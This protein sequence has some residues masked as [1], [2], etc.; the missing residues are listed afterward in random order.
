VC[1]RDSTR[2]LFACRTMVLGLYMW[3]Y[4]LIALNDASPLSPF[5]ASRTLF[6]VQH[7]TPLLGYLI[8]VY[9][10]YIPCTALS[11]TNLLFT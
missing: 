6:F 10:L 3:M 11:K 8:G 9:V 5:P 4:L 7:R 2:F 1:G